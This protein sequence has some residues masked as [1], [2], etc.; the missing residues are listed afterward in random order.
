MIHRRHLLTLAATIGSA[1]AVWAQPSFPHKPLKIVV[2]NAAGGAAD[3]TARTVG[4]KLSEALG[5]P[6]VIDNKPSAGGIVAA[7][8]VAK[9]EPDGHTMLLI[10]S[11]HPIQGLLKKHLNYDAIKDF[12]P[13]VLAGTAPVFMMAH[14]QVPVK[15][16]SDVVALAKAKPGVINFASGPSGAIPHLAGELFKAMA[17][18]NLMHIPYKGAGVAVNDLISGRVQV[19]FFSSPSPNSF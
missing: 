19:S 2:P 9:A 14:V 4:Q 17:G 13:I 1:P 15:T 18:V 11:S 6:V 7:D 5:Q 3:I 10:S 16:V 12:A 8:L